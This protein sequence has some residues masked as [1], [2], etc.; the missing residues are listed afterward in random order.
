[1]IKVYC[2]KEPIWEN[3]CHQA[4]TLKEVIAFYEAALAT[5]F[6]K[7]WVYEEGKLIGTIEN[8][9]FTPTPTPTDKQLYVFVYNHHKEPS[10]FVRSTGG[11]VTS[12]T[13]MECESL[14]H[15]IQLAESVAGKSCDVLIL[16][17]DPSR[18]RYTRLAGQALKLVATVTSAKVTR[19]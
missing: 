8:K 17:I 12:S 7:R 6:P 11:H 16:Q 5:R 1:M 3:G 18:V 14:D 9:V 10:E 4:D 2:G 19:Y 15:A 13:T